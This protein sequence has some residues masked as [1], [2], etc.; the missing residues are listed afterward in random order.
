MSDIDPK[1]TLIKLS[2]STLTVAD[3]AEDV[4][5]SKV[6]DRNGDDIGTVD[7]LL[8]DDQEHRVRFLEVAH[9]GFLGI[10]EEHFL[11]PVDA[12]KRIDADHVHIDRQRADL[13]EVPGYN[14]ALAEAPDYYGNVYGWWGYSPYWV[15]GYAY[16]P[17]PAGH[18]IH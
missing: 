1:G 14:P 2:D 8:L 18:P 3:P 16:P 12:V 7:D 15:P 10:G 5:G 17:Y 6:L 11:V 4:R 9:G 13:S